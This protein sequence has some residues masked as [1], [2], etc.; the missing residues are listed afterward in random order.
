MR[1]V[2]IRLFHGPNLH[3]P[4]PALRIGLRLGSGAGTAPREVPGFLD[5]LLD[6]LPA[7]REHPGEPASRLRDG[8]TV[9]AVLEHV[10]LELCRAAGVA[11]EFARVVPVRSPARP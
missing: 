5:R 8:A 2:S 4:R 11:A 1:I 7:Q 10:V 9:E 3:S 6:L